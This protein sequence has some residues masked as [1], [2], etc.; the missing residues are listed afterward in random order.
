[1]TSE[2]L[3]NLESTRKEENLRQDQEDGALKPEKLSKD[4]VL[5]ILPEGTDKNLI[6]EYKGKF[7]IE[8]EPTDLYL[9][10]M[11][12]EEQEIEEEKELFEIEKKENIHRNLLKKVNGKWIACG[13]NIEE[14]KKQRNIISST[15]SRVDVKY[16][17]KKE[18]GW[19]VLYHTKE[20][21]IKEWENIK[22]NTVTDKNNKT[23]KEF[24]EE[25]F[26]DFFNN[27]KFLEDLVLT[28]DQ[29]WKMYRLGK[30]FDIEEWKIEAEKD[31]SYNDDSGRTKEQKRKDQLFHRG[32]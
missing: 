2:S 10:H 23:G 28:D 3:F 30:F 7:F 9:E 8:G 12:K 32:N 14:F 6:E 31:R 29:Q 5:A 13:M 1:M 24:L 20:Y 27:R 19:Y 17:S 21:P 22:E 26:I 15:Y 11:K 18:D 4:E 25:N 16:L